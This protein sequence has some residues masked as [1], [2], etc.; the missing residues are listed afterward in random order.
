MNRDKIERLARGKTNSKISAALAR[1]PSP[2]PPFILLIILQA[3]SSLPC[4]LARH[5]GFHNICMSKSP[6]T[7]CCPSVYFLHSFFFPWRPWG[8]A[9][10]KG[11]GES[12]VYYSLAFKLLCGYSTIRLPNALIDLCSIT[13]SILDIKSAQEDL[14]QSTVRLYP[15]RT[16][17][18]LP[19]LK[20]P[21][22]G[23]RSLVMPK[24]FIRMDP[25][26]WKWGKVCL[27]KL[28]LE[29]RDDLG[30]V[31][32]FHKAPSMVPTPGRHKTT[33]ELGPHSKTQR[34]WD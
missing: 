28:P 22:I 17:V 20:V 10:L 25:F 27:L 16:T 13:A 19:L 7:Y 3:H 5:T 26:S 12:P 31:K 9:K 33:E 18:Y 4:P 15:A 6:W 14:N 34:K 1:T 8:I 21:W 11:V 30:R 2:T 32:S 23:K 24:S 29:M